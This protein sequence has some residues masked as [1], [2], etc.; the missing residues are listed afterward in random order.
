MKN[1]LLIIL[2]VISIAMIVIGISAKILP[3]ALT[4]IGFI[5]IAI[6]LYEKKR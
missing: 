2:L 4:G 6:I 3:P 5:V 1:N